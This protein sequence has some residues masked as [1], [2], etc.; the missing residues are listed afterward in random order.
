MEAKQQK[1]LLFAKVI[2]G[3]ISLCLLLVTIFV[4]LGSKKVKEVEHTDYRTS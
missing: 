2:I 1:H 4:F 3:S